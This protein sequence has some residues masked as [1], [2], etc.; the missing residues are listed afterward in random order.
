MKWLSAGLVFVNLSTVCGLLLG[1]AGSGLD[2]HS[3]IFALVSGAA[4][5]FAAYLGTS[6]PNKPNCRADA[7]PASPGSASEALALQR[8]QPEVPLSKRGQRRLQKNAPRSTPAPWRYRKVWLWLLGACFLM[9]AVRSFCWLL[10]IDGNQLKIQSPNNLG[11][12]GLHVTLIRNFAS[13][14]ALWPDNPIYVFSKLRYPAGMDLFNALL[15]LAHVDLIRG[16]VWTGLLASLATFYAFFR[17]AGAFG[18]AGFLFNGG[19]AGFQFFKTLKFLD[20]QGD[21]TIAWKSIALSMFV[22]QRGLL[23]AIPV[24]V[25]LLWHWREKFFTGAPVAGVDNPGT[26]TDRIQRSGPLPFWV[27]LSLYASM[28]LFHVHTFLALTIALIFL[29]LFERPSELT[30]IINVARKERVTGIGHLISH[31]VMWPEIFRDAPI[32]RHA[33][34]L[35]AAALIPATFF[36]WLTT[37]HFHAASI[38]KWHPGWVQESGDFA[39]PFFRIGPVNFGTD[40]PF[41][42][43][44]AQKTWNGVIAP[45]F[46][47]WLTNFGLWVPLALALVGLC[48]WRAW[49]AG[50]RWGNRPPADIA[51]VLPA[52]GIF[53]VGYFFQTAPWDWDNLKL[54]MWGYFLVLPFLWSDLIARWAVPVRVVVCIVLFGSGFITL[55][56]GL[57][58]NRGGWG[59]A[60]RTELDALGDAIRQ[61]PVEARFAAY[62]TFNHPLLL[63]GRKV[64]LGYP[65]HLW[66]QGFADYTRP[67]NLLNQLMRGAGNWREIARTLRVRYI[68]WGREEK[69]N[70]P[71]ST[72]P[73]ET[74][75]PL[76]ASGQWGAIYD[77]GPTGQE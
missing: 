12:L 73:W 58:A 3:A 22:T 55:L 5:A 41:L 18:V 62:P 26:Q 57:A 40:I 36:V 1:M 8:A 10:Y 15:C 11:D 9:F 51:F 4:F 54:M 49:K 48:G 38:I 75:L 53:A 31:P 61:L 28:P 52:V 47:F 17:W 20:Y 37:D 27:E 67:N 56:G 69:T 35:L 30:F 2:K 21:K 32:R 77:L 7:S 24:G 50:W 34:A 19:I 42:W 72:R 29:S 6:D 14:V 70:Y 16:L 74:T 68:F 63:Q 64:A 60:D 76:V 45:F 44:F 25:L 39:A 43:S 33:G 66:S 71:A 23:Y 13:G 59:F 65:G 46:Q